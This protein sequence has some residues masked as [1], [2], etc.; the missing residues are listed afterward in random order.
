MNEHLVHLAQLAIEAGEPLDYW[1]EK[2]PGILKEAL[3]KVDYFQCSICRDIKRGKH[4]SIRGACVCFS[5]G[6]EISEKLQDLVGSNA[7]DESQM[8]LFPV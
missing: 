5:C 3:E 7:L 4:V 8:R 6:D 1:R 2:H